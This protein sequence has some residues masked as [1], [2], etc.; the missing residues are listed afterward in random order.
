MLSRID[1]TAHPHGS[2]GITR[3]Q[4]MRHASQQVGVA[5]HRSVTFYRQIAS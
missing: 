4:L 1:Q 3:S 5:L 2:F